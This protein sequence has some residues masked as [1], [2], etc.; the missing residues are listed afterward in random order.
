MAK[1]HGRGQL[2]FPDGCCY[3]GAF[4]ADQKNGP[5]TMEWAD[6]CRYTGEWSGGRQHGRGAY[7]DG[8]IT[9]EGL[10]EMGRRKAALNLAQAESA[11]V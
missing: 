6:G 8:R 10:W 4:E 2:T 9:T 7:Y 11:R 3:D 1:K 5:G